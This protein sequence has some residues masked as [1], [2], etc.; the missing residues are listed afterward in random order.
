MSVSDGLDTT[1]FNFQIT[2]NNPPS[3]IGSITAT[4]AVT[5]HDY[6]LVIDDSLFSDDDGFSTLTITCTPPA[7]LSFTGSLTKTLA[8]TGIAASVAA[9]SPYSITITATDSYS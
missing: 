8:V 6:S 1:V 3:A 4:S 9:S 7:F 5:G 2:V